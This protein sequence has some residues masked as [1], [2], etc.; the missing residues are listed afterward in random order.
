[1]NIP[2]WCYLYITVFNYL[3]SDILLLSVQA[4]QNDRFTAAR[5]LYCEWHFCNKNLL[6]PAFALCR[7]KVPEVFR[8]QETNLIFRLRHAYIPSLITNAEEAIHIAAACWIDIEVMN[9]L[10]CSF[11]KFSSTSDWYPPL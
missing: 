1:M 6:V 8:G 7:S 9:F 5:M 11:C 2:I 3:T 4:L 10:T